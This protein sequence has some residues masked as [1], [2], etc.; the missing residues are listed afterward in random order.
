MVQQ[1]LIAPVD[2]FNLIE[3][4]KVFNARFKNRILEWEIGNGMI[5]KAFS[6]MRTSQ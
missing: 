1:P 6:S 4:I 3:G 2:H 5:L